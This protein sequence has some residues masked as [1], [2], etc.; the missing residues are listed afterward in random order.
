MSRPVTG[1]RVG[2]V[3]VHY[4]AP[5]S[6]DL[7][8]TA[9]A[10]S[11]V[12][13][14][15]VVAD[16]GSATPPDPG[17]RPYPV[18]VVTQP[19][20]GFRAAAARNLG[21]RALL[22]ADPD[23]EALFFLDG[24]TIP[25]AGYVPALLAALQETAI[26]APD[27]RA[28]VV[29]R[30]RYADLAGL[31]PDEVL[32]FVAEPSRH[33]ERVLPDT[34]WLDEG[35]AATELLRTAD[36]R[37]YRFVISAVLGLTRELWEATGG[38]DDS[39]VGYGGEDWDLANRAWLAGADLRHAPN[40]V[41]WHDGPDASGRDVESDEHTRLSTK[42]LET[43]RVAEVVTEPGAR[44][45]GL[46]WAN[47]DVVIEVDDDGWRSADTLL[48]CADL[49]RGTDARIWLSRGGILDD[50]TWPESD[51]RVQRRPVDERVRLRARHRVRVTRP[52]RLRTP[53]ADLCARAPLDLPGLTIARTRDLARAQ[54]AEAPTA[55][56][57]SP[58]PAEVLD[59]V[60]A[61]RPDGRL[62]AEWGWL[63]TDELPPLLPADRTSRTPSTRTPQTNPDPGGPR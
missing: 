55:P 56:A 34:A 45:P 47:P 42:D 53:L 59:A 3:V 22:E 14:Q 29:G 38:F 11:P 52:L 61:S 5:R 9:L 28:L 62:E 44:D 51:P 39:F 46:L 17:P 60:R 32:A 26:E 12:P 8:L 49:L 63:T 21:A 20:L 18:R 25:T 48:T 13:L 6:L 57:S 10:D 41:A 24:D 2:V 31:T 54:A 40:A 15:V 43:R 1:P 37:S 27:R 35:Y 16:D 30:R 33:S 23:V 4:E 50:G 36:D 19:D 7:V 58:P